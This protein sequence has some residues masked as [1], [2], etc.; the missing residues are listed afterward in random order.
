MIKLSSY[1]NR[2]V[3]VTGGNGNM[4]RAIIKKF[5]SYGAKCIAID[6]NG[7]SNVIKCNL[8][9]E[10]ELK[11]VFEKI[12]KLNKITD[13]I[14]A[15]GTIVVGTIK[16]STLKEFN[17]NIDNNLKTAFLV[18]KI[19]ST[20]IINGGSLIFISSQAALKGAKYW[21]IY[22]LSKAAI[23][24]LSETLANELSNKKIRVNSI[25]PGDVE[26]NMMKYAI[27][28]IA[29]FSNKKESIIYN[30]YIS[31]I[32]LKRFAKPSEIAD[33]CFYLS[34][35]KYITGTTHLV[36]GGENS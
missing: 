6:L 23:L 20:K 9:N 29:K 11:S 36:D 14:H 28:K 12:S 3:V 27:K 4:G 19:S 35:S 31:N 15:A 1:T 10:K 18:G 32:P 26:G 33:A 21:G 7:N 24:R 34:N 2:V 17:N 25:C 5:K 22:S 13:V 8:T 16:N 30:N